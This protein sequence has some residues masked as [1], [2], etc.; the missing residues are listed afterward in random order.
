MTRFSH[1]TI[2]LSLIALIPTAALAQQGPVLLD[3]I[4][5][6]AAADTATIGS[7][8]SPRPGGQTAGRARIGALGDQDLATAPFRAEAYTE[9]LIRDQQA[10][11]LADVTRNDPSVRQDAP[12]FSERDSFFIRGFSV[13]N[14]D[15]LFDGL[16]YIAN[17]RRSALEGI[18]RV[19][20]LM[21]P[22]ALANGGVGR[23]GGTITLIPKRAEDADL[24][25]ITTGIASDSQVWTHADLGRRFGPRREFGARANLSWRGGDTA[26]DR[27]SA[28][29]GVATLGLDY[30]GDRL[31]ATLDL[32]AS[33]QDLDAP[34][35]L[36]NAAA[37]GLAIPDAPDGRINTANPFEFHDS[38]HRML[39]SRV[40]YDL[41]AA[42]TVYG[43]FGASRYR[44]DFLTSNYTITGE[45]GEAVNELG[46]NP[47]E[48]EGRA[49]EIGLRSRLR[50]GAVDH[51]ISLSAAWSLNRNNRGE[52]NPRLLGF[53]VAGTNIYD[54]R[55]LD[56]APD[57]SGLP[58]ADGLIPFADLRSR[59]VA[60]A[61]T[62]SL[63]E[64]RVQLT[65]GGRWQQIRT[66]GFNTRPGNPDFPVGEQNYLA[67]DSAFTPALAASW[68][69]APGV[70]VYG[71]YVEALTEGPTAPAVALNAG[72]IFPAV[73]NRQ[74]E[75][76]A[77][78]DLGTVTLG[79][80]LFEIRQPNGITDP[81]TGLFSLSGQQ[82]N[83]G[84]ELSA[85]GQ[86][87]EGFRILGGVTLMDAELRRTQAG[88]FDGND[89]PGVARAAASLYAE[90]DLPAVQG[91]TLN[92]RLMHGGSTWYDQ[93][94]T[95]KV[96]GWT[97]LDLGT[98]YSLQA[99]GR[100]VE[101]R[102]NVE[103]VLNESYW[104]SSARGFLSAGAPRTY[105][106]S[107]SM[108]F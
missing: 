27:N 15:T 33:K 22:T 44:E 16:P 20:L 2:G 30:R 48:I 40:E 85:A 84:L 105:A 75:L 45:D 19:D 51:R 28:E 14:L 79:A 101:L 8:A 3:G 100:E 98:R 24:T 62:M 34:T 88:A 80:S 86:P 18:A 69:V 65:F 32:N 25:R 29:V 31:R 49:A 54:P 93:A 7:P 67:E 23:V 66:R 26:L 63:D 11:S 87:A 77:R 35:S 12:T 90:Y 52:F 76:G 37:P 59:S 43:A 81:G 9:D 38:D 60:L 97:R 104:A 42:T 58:R 82:R 89:V 68:Q 78:Y 106:L 94:N 102:A 21:G 53:P 50:T 5:L 46:F 41:G 103:N 1:L 91:L 70:T 13:P 10:R 71:N 56:A 92:G 64:D 96:A 17:P 47:Q 72:E 39:A 107:A 61:D 36:F 57:L 55:F 99:Q 4:T 73:V 95:Q 108:R 83:R 6:D 74:R